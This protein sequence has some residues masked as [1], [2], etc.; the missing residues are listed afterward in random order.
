M[1]KNK[2]GKP[3]AV[4]AEIVFV[5]GISFETVAKRLMDFLS[6]NSKRTPVPASIH[7]KDGTVLNLLLP[8]AVNSAFSVELYLKCLQVLATG[9]CPWGHDLL[10][11]FDDLPVQIQRDIEREYHR[12]LARAGIPKGEKAAHDRT[13]DSYD[14][15]GN[16]RHE[17]N[18]FKDFRYAFQA[19]ENLSYSS[20]PIAVALKSSILRLKPEWLKHADPY[21]QATMQG[22]SKQK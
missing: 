19:K 2:K 8:I 3:S 14:L 11:L 1:S 13:I 18:S 17:K 9:R 21:K 4:D 16:L 20:Q 7:L 10:E 22:R 5:S 6:A 12:E 15:R